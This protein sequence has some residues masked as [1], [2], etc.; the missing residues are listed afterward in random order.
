MRAIMT[1]MALAGANEMRKKSDFFGLLSLTIKNLS[2]DIR[3]ETSGTRHNA[4]DDAV[5][6][7]HHLIKIF[8]NNSLEINE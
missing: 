8:N 6:Q 7:A 4:L 5:S 1:M 3:I 2:P